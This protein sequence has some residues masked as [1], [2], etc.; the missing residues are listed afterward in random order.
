MQYNKEIISKCW[1]FNFC[2]TVC[3]D[4]H[5][6]SF[7]HFFFLGK[8]LLKKQLKLELLHSCLAKYVNL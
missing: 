5:S 7:A 6:K 8:Q 2:V 4:Y 3:Y 1:T